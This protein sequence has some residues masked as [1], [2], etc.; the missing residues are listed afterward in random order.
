MVIF[1]FLNGTQQS[2]PKDPNLSFTKN[3]NTLQEGEKGFTFVMG[4]M[5]VNSVRSAKP[6]Q[7][8]HHCFQ[9]SPLRGQNPVSKAVLHQENKKMTLFFFPL[10]K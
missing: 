9:G 10:C 4:T 6:S 5:K 1:F 3:Y 2:Q 7:L 8:L